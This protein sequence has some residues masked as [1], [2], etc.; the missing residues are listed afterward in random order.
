MN[1]FELAELKE[2]EILLKFCEA[3]N[4]KTFSMTPLNSRL[5]YDIIIGDKILGEIKI[6]NQASTSFPTTL[7]EEKK[8][9]ALFEFAKDSNLIPYY[10]VYFEVDKVLMWWN[11]E[12]C[13]K[14][15]IILNCPKSTFGDKTIIEKKCF[16][17]SLDSCN[18]TLEF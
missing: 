14:N 6:R 13:Q 5:I 11:L 8:Y 15:S 7:L 4:F 3:K 9:N 16:T 12:R 2:R 17:L 18:G 1:K 10:F